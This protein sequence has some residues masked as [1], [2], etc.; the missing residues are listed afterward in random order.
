MSPGG[1][2]HSFALV[3]ESQWFYHLRET[4]MASTTRIQRS[5]NRSLEEHARQRVHLG[6]LQR[7]LTERGHARRTIHGYLDCAAHFCHWAE[8]SGLEL[9]RTDEKVIEHFRDKHLSA[10]RLWQ[11]DAQRPA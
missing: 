3:V 5:V 9:A 6:A 11:A 10:L 7:Y 4:A 2:R 8:R 1:A